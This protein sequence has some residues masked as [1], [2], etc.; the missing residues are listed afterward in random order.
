MF[1]KMAGETLVVDIN[2]DG[3]DKEGLVCEKLVMSC[4]RLEGSK[5][6]KQV[7]RINDAFTFQWR[8]SILV[9]QLLALFCLL[10]F[11]VGVLARYLA[12]PWERVAREGERSDRR[13]NFF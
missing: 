2:N 11:F 6:S 10:G 12:C 9:G 8:G 13:D 1:C 4:I 7:M 5:K 3:Y